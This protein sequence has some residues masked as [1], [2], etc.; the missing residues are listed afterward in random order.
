[1]ARKKGKLKEKIKKAKKKVKEKV[2]KVTSKIK[3]YL[4][5]PQLY[6]FLPIMKKTLNKRGIPYDKKSPQ[7]I[8]LQFYKGVILKQKRFEYEQFDYVSFEQTYLDYE[9]GK[10]DAVPP[11]PYGE[12]VKIVIEF[13]KNMISKIKKGKKS[14]LNPDEQELSED[15]YKTDDDPKSKEIVER[16][17]KEQETEN[18]N[19]ES[20][21]EQV[22]FLDRILIALGLKKRKK[23]R[24][25]YLFSYNEKTSVP[26]IEQNN[27]HPLYYERKRILTADGSVRYIYEYPYG[28]MFSKTLNKKASSFAKVIAQSLPAQSI[29][30]AIAKDQTDKLFIFISNIIDKAEDK[31]T[32]SKTAK[33]LHN[34]ANINLKKAIRTLPKVYYVQ[35]YDKINKLKETP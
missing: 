27:K 13:I 9:I 6:P 24:S 33:I 1:M 10:H 11:L 32:L 14:E 17:K 12:I 25:N 18:E 35:I 4:I 30:Q 19:E 26:E 22:G 5:P 15:L 31:L 29:K 8:V 2:K 20:D 34:R 28:K 7:D 3:K 23:K 21:D 16:A